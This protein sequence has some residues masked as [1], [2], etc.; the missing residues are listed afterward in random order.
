MEQ[1]KAQVLAELQR[2][3]DEGLSEEELAHT[4]TQKRG[5][6]LIQNETNLNQ[7]LMLAI[8]ELTGRGYTW[9]DDYMNFF[10]DVTSED[11]KEAAERYFQNYTEVLI[12]P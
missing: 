1:A 6:Y 11:I 8:T 9:V 12:V 7:A 3:A 10:D 4:A 5:M 2:F